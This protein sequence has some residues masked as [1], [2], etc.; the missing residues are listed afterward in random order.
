MVRCQESWVWTCKSVHC[1]FS[2][3]FST[4]SI[5]IFTIVNCR[6][7]VSK[8]WA[9][10]ILACIW[11]YINISIWYISS[12]ALSRC[13]SI[14]LS[15]VRM[16]RCSLLVYSVSVVFRRTGIYSCSFVAEVSNC[17][18]LVSYSSISICWSSAWKSRLIS[19]Y[20]I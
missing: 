11:T 19:D 1:A 9:L 20:S 4:Q 13:S 16:T 10:Q 5:S 8:R 2:V 12:C 14:S 15:S 18:I 17:R 7:V 3:A 6:V